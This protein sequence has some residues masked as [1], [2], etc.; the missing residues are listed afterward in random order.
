MEPLDFQNPYGDKLVRKKK[1]RKNKVVQQEDQNDTK[2][3]YPTYN[4]YQNEIRNKNI[5]QDNDDY[6]M[7]MVYLNRKPS[8]TKS[9]DN[10]QDTFEEKKLPVLPK[11]LQTNELI[12]AHD[13]LKKKQKNDIKDPQENKISKLTIIL[14]VI[15]AVLVV[16]VIVLLVLT[17]VFGVRSSE[18]QNTPNS[19]S[20]ITT[21][22][23]Y[24]FS[25]PN[26]SDQCGL[27]FFSQNARISGAFAA[28]DH[29]WPS[30]VIIEF[31]YKFDY[32]DSYGNYLS[33]STS[34]IC[35]G[36]LIN[37]NTV[38]TAAHCLI[39]HVNFT[40]NGISFYHKVTENNYYPT[41][42]SMY[43]VYL[44]IIDVNEVFFPNIVYPARKV[45]VMSFIRHPLYDSSVLMNDIAVIKL[46]S[47]VSLDEYVQLACLPQNSNYAE[48]TDVWTAGWDLLNRNN[49]VLLSLKMQNTRFSLFD[50]N[51]CQNV[52]D[53]LFKD[54]NSQICAGDAYGTNGSCSGEDGEPL[55]FK[56]QVNGVERF[57]LIGISSYIEGCEGLPA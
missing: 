24:G 25:G 40:A 51:Q 49:S 30:I 41:F 1:N 34:K 28:S 18:N 29:S 35:T 37:R 17:I 31:N 54:S 50:M 23:S 38:L 45:S 22:C 21:T 27:V 3:D 19:T 14:L 2:I 6:I 12:D 11:P 47:S 53:G 46:R 48:G 13:K 16:L 43:T 52:S 15:I 10:S 44:G 26:C 20:T 9:K 4:F 7:D 55:F 36:A 42:E 33:H 5:L 8:E 57:V 32:T 56:D 39:E